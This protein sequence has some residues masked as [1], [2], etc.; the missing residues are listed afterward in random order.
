MAENLRDQLVSTTTRQAME[1]ADLGVLPKIYDPA[2]Q[3]LVPSRPDRM[4]ILLAALLL[5]P[6]LGAGLAF[7]GETTDATL[8]TLEDIRRVV[9][10][11][12]L[13]TTP[14]LRKLQPR[15]RGLRRYWLPARCRVSWC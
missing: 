13:C 4:K 1:S 5:G 3:P 14:L 9:P 8:R 10:E 7:L 15:Q 12:V 11:P 2:K 6:V